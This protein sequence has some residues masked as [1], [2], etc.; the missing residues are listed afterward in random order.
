MPGGTRSTGTRSPSATRGRRRNSRIH[1]RGRGG[2]REDKQRE[3]EIPLV[4]TQ[5]VGTLVFRRSAALTPPPRGD[6]LPTGGA[7]PTQSVGR[8]RSHAERGNEGM[9][10]A[11]F[12]SIW[13]SFFSAPSAPSVVNHFFTA[14][15][16]LAERDRGL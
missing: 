2:R 7:A 5:S 8:V 9:H 12:L 4:P 3:R 1:R 11:L 13:V 6:G 10:S 16:S 14:H 15:R